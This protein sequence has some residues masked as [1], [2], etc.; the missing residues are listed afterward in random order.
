MQM[1]KQLFAT[2]SQAVMSPGNKLM[3]VGHL[4]LQ[5]T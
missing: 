3:K 5:P 4:L 1:F 2:T